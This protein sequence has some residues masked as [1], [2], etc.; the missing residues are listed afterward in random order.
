MKTSFAI[1]YIIIVLSIPTFSQQNYYDFSQGDKSTVFYDDF[2]N[3]ISKHFIGDFQNISAGIVNGEYILQ[4]KTNIY[5]IKFITHQPD[6]NFAKPVLALDFSRDF[7]VETSIKV[8]NYAKDTDPFGLIIGSRWTDFKIIDRFMRFSFSPNSQFAFQLFVDDK[9]TQLLDWNKNLNVKKDNFNKLTYRKVGSQVYCFLNELL[10]FSGPS[11]ALF[12][13]NHGVTFGPFSKIALDYY[14]ISYLNIDQTPP[15]ISVSNPDVSRGFKILEQ[16]NQVSIEGVASDN[17]EIKQVLLNGENILLRP[18]GFFQKTILLQNGDNIY[19][20]K[21]I[22]KWNNTSVLTFTIQKTDRIVTNDVNN[23]FGKYY[24]LI[25][26]NNVYHDQSISSLNDPIN[27]ATKLFN[28]LT[29]R[30]T[31]DPGNIILLKNATYV[32]II[33]AFDKLSNI[34][35]PNDNLLVFYAGHGWWDDGRKLGYWLPVDSKKSS[36]AFWIPNSRISDYMGSIHSK[37]TLLIADACFS[38]SIFKTRSAFSDAQPAINKLYELPSR[39]AMTSGNMK[40]VP[41]KSAF[42]YYLVNRLSQNDEKYISSDVLFASFRQ[43][44]LN[45]SPTEPQYGTIQNAGD[46]GGEFIFILR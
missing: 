26:G 46:E 17:G 38:G 5:W 43:A 30:Y 39:K 12:G 44:V 1:L 2:D 34:I 31:F 6:N 32:Q 42:L 7:E 27:D 3:N 22:D 18:D 35:T 40:E 36:T 16:N 33:E 29:S 8:L 10:V 25:I 28:V 23:K 13:Q 9:W 11:H 14:R 20:I 37:H 21:A 19:T 41:D 24:A 4:N 45:N 15:V